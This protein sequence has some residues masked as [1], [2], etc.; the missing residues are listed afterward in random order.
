MAKGL[1][2]SMARLS[3]RSRSVAC[4]GERTFKFAP[5][6][7]ALLVIDMQRDF[8]G[9][10]G[11]DDPMRAVIPRVAEL[12]AAARD[13]GVTVVHTRESYKPDMSDVSEYRKS[14]GYVGRRGPQGRFL[15]RGEAG[16]D[17]L[18]E[19]SP[20]PG[21]TV[22]DKAG[23]NAFY[24]SNLQSILK[25][26]GVERLIICGV[27]TQCCVHSTLRDAV[28][29]G[30]WCLTVA[31]C[32]AAE[33]QDLH[34]ATLAIIRGEGDLFGWVCDVTDV[35]PALRRKRSGKK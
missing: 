28:D 27:T 31:D 12:L 4:W 6:R 2:G 1:A 32:C 24:G 11:E 7:T 15:I 13:A 33:E 21:E 17:F 19:L 30:Y 29:R 20:L 16:C 35:T 9:E 8:F 26:G 23:F 3:I 5:A 34:D 25:R 22:I 14:L 10:P 18:D